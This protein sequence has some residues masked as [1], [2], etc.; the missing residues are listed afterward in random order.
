MRPYVFLS[1]LVALCII[2]AV[3]IAAGCN[4]HSGSST[5]S[6]LELYTSEGCS[7]C[8]PADK[9]LSDLDAGKDLKLVPLA[10]HVDYWDYIGW[11][12]RF[13]K[14]QFSERQKIS[15]S[16]SASGVVYTPQV[17][18]NGTDFRGWGDSRFS[19]M[20]TD[21]AK[22][23][24]RADLGLALMP[25]ASGA[26]NISATAKV[27]DNRVRNADFYIAVYENGLKSTVK[28]GENNGRELRHDHV[29]R[30]WFG[31]YKLDTTNMVMRDLALK[32]EWKGRAGGVAVFVQNHDTGDV[33]QALRLP[34]C[35]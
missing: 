13:A 17:M 32:P 6:L 23:P 31:P 27:K 7:S 12:D 10:L 33:L 30:E 28:A 20:V 5:V 15:A 1:W 26:M 16:K 22:Q 29:V 4:A 9:W 14:A 18:L 21:T 19:R 25:V 2:P 11:K 3:A 24:A 8:P 35:S 34:F